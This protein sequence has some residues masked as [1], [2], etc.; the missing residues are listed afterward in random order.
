MSLAAHIAKSLQLPE[1]YVLMLAATASHRYKEFAIKKSD[2]KS[3]RRIEQPSKELK[4]LQRWLVRRVFDSLPT[5]PCAHAYVR[6]RSI[7][8]NAAVHQ[9]GRY[10]S[11]LDLENFFPSL[12]SG[13]V[14]SLLKSNR[15][16]ADGSKLDDRDI[17]LIRALVCR[18]GKLTIGAPSSPTVSNK[19]LYALDMRITEM[20]EPLNVNYSRYADDLY[21]SSSRPGV[22]ADVCK[23]AEYIVVNAPTPKLTINKNKTYHAS[24]KKRMAVTGLRITPEANISVGQ[25]LKRKIRSL[26]HKARN[27]EIK[28]DDLGSLRGLLAY[29][30]SIEPSFSERIRSKYKIE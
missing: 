21:F 19:L 23:K 17:L 9:Q 25:D 3:L 13:D 28:A 12:T 11:R 2:G 5:H 16:L 7:R 1:P 22:L 14:E 29:V 26:A 20:T 4:L 15:V 18:F 30:S 24:R 27:K 8:T 6:G 10:I